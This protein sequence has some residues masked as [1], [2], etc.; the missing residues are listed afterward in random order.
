M[1]MLAKRPE[2]AYSVPSL[3][4]AGAS[5]ACAGAMIGVAA[6]GNASNAANIV[7]RITVILPDDF[8]LL[9]NKA[10]ATGWL[11]QL[12]LNAQARQTYR[13]SWRLTSTARRCRRRQYPLPSAPRGCARPGAGRGG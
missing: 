4:S 13:R 8:R 2:D 6:I 5:P 9:A 1:E 3:I 7:C 10:R 12:G 11:E